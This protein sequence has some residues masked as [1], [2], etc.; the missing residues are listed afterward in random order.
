MLFVL[1]KHVS[2]IMNDG[3]IKVFD[4]KLIR[5]WGWNTKNYEN[6]ATTRWWLKTHRI[7]RSVFPISFSKRIYFEPILK[8]IAVF[9]HGFR[10]QH[11]LM[12]L[13]VMGAIYTWCYSFNSTKNWGWFNHFI[14]VPIFAGW[15]LLI[16]SRK[17]RI[18]EVSSWYETVKNNGFHVKP[19]QKSKLTILK[20]NFEIWR[21]IGEDLICNYNIVY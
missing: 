13:V 8:V 6:M 10:L 3:R 11:Y 16:R 12:L 18:F 7:F 4:N 9:R 15:I 17:L 21:Q 20:I 5:Q 14:R 1:P 2:A 19:L